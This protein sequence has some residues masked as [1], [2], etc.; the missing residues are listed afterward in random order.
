VPLG[1]RWRSI[2]L[3][4]ALAAVPLVLAPPAAAQRRVPAP[5]SQ[6]VAA[7]K[8]AP[9]APAPA[10]VP[11]AGVPRPVRPAR[12]KA[13]DPTEPARRKQ[14]QSRLEGILARK[15]LSRIQTGVQVVD[16]DGEV[17]FS[18]HADT[19]LKAASNTKIFTTGA[20]MTLL[21]SDFQLRTTVVGKEPDE[22]GVVHGDLYLR[23]AGDPF[24]S[25]ANLQGLAKRLHEYGVRRVTGGIVADES[26]EGVE[27][28]RG[29]G[30]LMLD[31][32]TFHV[33]VSPG[34]KVKA[35]PHAS[36]APGL[37]RYFKL[38]NRAVTVKKGKMRLTVTTRDVGAHTVVTVAGR[39]PLG[40]RAVSISRNPRH[41][42]LFVGH[43]L[44][45]MLDA[46][47]ITV[48]GGVRA[49]RAPQGL[50]LLA[51]HRSPTLAVM[52]RPINKNSNN[53][54]AE[55][56]FQVTG[57]ELYGGPPSSAKGSKA[58]AEG[59]KKL[60]LEPAANTWSQVDGSGLSHSNRMTPAFVTEVLR[61][62]HLGDPK[63]QAD[64]FQ[65]LAVGGRDGTIRGRFPA[66]PEGGIVFGKTGTLR[67]T[68][69]LSG[70]V[71]T[72]GKTAIFSILMNGTRRRTLKPAVQAQ[73]EI[74]MAVYRY[75]AGE[76][77]AA[78][79]LPEPP[80]GE[81]EREGP[82]EPVFDESREITD[83]AP[84]H[85]PGLR[86]RLPALQLPP[87]WSP[88]LAPAP[89]LQAPLTER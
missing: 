10:S 84:A 31:H 23:G 5:A 3:L 77:A 20:A 32:S 7:K 57:A 29:T 2:A 56:I 39:I 53:G 16:P 45:N 68:K 25:S 26:R 11:R 36:V 78:V 67:D 48:A 19:M 74:A 59:L 18:H 58:V 79:A 49:G 55:R 24:L 4:S 51:D 82:E 66:G 37:S 6:P 27:P 17:L 47:G 38:V 43:A 80:A 54:M 9:A 44:R 76:A 42:S 50:V 87:A 65:S 28:G 21:G 70:Y 62:L 52:A 64:F 63:L 83:D 69:C 85:G 33:V 72:G 34:P 81:P 13:P 75:L 46:Q 15:P 22:K 14:L 12:V 8:A 71:R 60:G 1:P 41:S 86:L 89:G 88:S 35:R 73:N 40:H 30:G 61:Q